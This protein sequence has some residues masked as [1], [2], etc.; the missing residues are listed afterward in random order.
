MMTSLDAAKTMPD[1]D[2]ETMNDHFK[3]ARWY[4]PL[5]TLH[6]SW[7]ETFD[8]LQLKMIACGNDCCPSVNSVFEHRCCY[9]PP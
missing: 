3:N 7:T 6:V 5:P 8:H 9:R 4:T 2:S 1:A